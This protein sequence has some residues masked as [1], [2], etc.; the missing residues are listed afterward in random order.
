LK[1]RKRII[2]N[3]T[4]EKQKYVYLDNLALIK[5]NKETKQ[6]QLHSKHKN[7]LGIQTTP[8]PQLHV[9]TCVQIQKIIKASYLLLV[10]KTLRFLYQPSFTSK[11]IPLQL[12]T[13]VGMVK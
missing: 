1:A 13:K 2:I 5:P 10:K 9:C 7:A 6:T 4:F 11:N 3:Y 12:T 8:P